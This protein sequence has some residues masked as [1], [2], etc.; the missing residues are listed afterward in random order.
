MKID[1]RK[2]LISIAVSFIYHFPLLIHEWTNVFLLKKK[3]S[4][5]DSILD[6][7]DE[8]MLTI[9]GSIIYFPMWIV[10]FTEGG[11]TMTIWVYSTFIIS[12]LVIY[13]FLGSELVSNRILKKNKNT[14]ANKT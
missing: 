7:Y 3:Y 4:I 11:I 12:A 8:F 1:K 6:L 2:A 10:G 9:V 5:F 14:N 13:L